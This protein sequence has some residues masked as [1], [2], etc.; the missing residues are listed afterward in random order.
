MTTRPHWSCVVPTLF[1]SVLNFSPLNFAPVWLFVAFS[2]SFPFDFITVVFALIVN[3][4]SSNSFCTNLNQFFLNLGL[5]FTLINLFVNV[6]I[7]I[8]KSPI[9]FIPSVFA[10]TV[11]VFPFVFLTDVC[12]FSTSSLPSV[13][14][15]TFTDFGFNESIF[16]FNASVEL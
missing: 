7:A 2:T 9:E 3:V 5:I 4:L 13:F 6:F 14:A 16:F 1:I 11:T 12:K 8:L 10:C 15:S